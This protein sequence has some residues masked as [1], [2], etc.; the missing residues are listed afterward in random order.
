MYNAGTNFSLAVN[1]VSVTPF[2]PPEILGVTVTNNAAV[3]T[4]NSIASQTY[5][6]QSENS[7]I[8]GSWTNVGANVLATGTNSSATDTAI[9]AGQKFYRI[10]LV[11]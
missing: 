6:L 3:V 11:P 9:G 2:T 10:M 5:Q 8:A 7:V 4:W 1:N